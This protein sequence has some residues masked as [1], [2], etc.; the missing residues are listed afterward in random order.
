MTGS[1][2]IAL[3]LG[4]IAIASACQS[5]EEKKK[6]EAAALAAREQRLEARLAKADKDTSKDPSVAMWIMPTEL[7]E[8]SGLALT[9]DGRL[10]AHDD[11][12]SRI[13]EIDARRG[14]IVK[15]FLVGKGLHGD[16]EALTVAG[17]DMYLLQSNGTL[18][19]FKEGDNGKI[20][21]YQKLDLHLKK[22][23][24]FEGVT[25]QA[26]SAW[27]VLPCKTVRTKSLKDDMVMYRWKIGTNDS[28]GIS[29]LTVPQSEAVG[30]NKWKNFRPSDI[31]IDPATGDYV[32]I[33]SI[34]KGLVVMGTDGEVIRSEKLPGKHHQAE[35]V[36]I[37][38]DSLLIISDEASTKPAAIT[39]YRWHR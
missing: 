37:T 19:R 13:Y 9:P 11:E 34:D 38:K 32:I 17:S 1:Q 8:I 29:M 20:V 15:S 10:F 16:F 5:K 18:Y 27:L 4:V 14:T 36:A 21:P 2:R 23:C 3:I 22:E 12:I 31:T 28:T 25:Y 33:S 39:L 35:G 24:E 6:V 26:D 7:R 30:S